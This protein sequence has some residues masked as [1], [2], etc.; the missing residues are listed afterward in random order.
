[1]RRIT[2]SHSAPSTNFLPGRLPTT[3]RNTY[4]CSQPPCCLASYMSSG[5]GCIFFS[6]AIILR[7]ISCDTV[8][9]LLSIPTMHKRNTLKAFLRRRYHSY[10]CITWTPA[11]SSH[12]SQWLIEVMGKCV[13]RPPMSA[14]EDPAN[15]Q[16]TRSH[17]S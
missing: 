9:S 4:S 3:K 13:P 7:R 8:S 12:R 15:I 17:W 2:A 14:L 10:S 11:A 5:S 1:M 16:R 6:R